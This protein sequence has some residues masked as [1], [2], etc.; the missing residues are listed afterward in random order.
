MVFQNR[1]D[2][3]DFS[4]QQ[5]TAL[6]VLKD[7]MILKSIN[8]IEHDDLVFSATSNNKPHLKGFRFKQNDQDLISNDELSRKLGPNY[9]P[10]CS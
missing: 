8:V 5:Q 7:F 10:P 4:I 6:D 1:M 3:L 2:K 9:I